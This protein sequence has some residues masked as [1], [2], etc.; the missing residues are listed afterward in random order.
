MSFGVWNLCT[1]FLVLF[2][3][4]SIQKA[5]IDI[6]YDIQFSD[7]E[8]N[9]LS[10]IIAALTPVKLTVDALCRK[11]A[12]L[13]TADA[14]LTFMLDTLSKQKSAIAL[15]LLEALKSRILLRRTEL[16]QIFQYLQKGS[17]D[18]GEVFKRISKLTNI[19]KIVSLTKRLPHEN[20]EDTEDMEVVQETSLP[21]SSQIIN[22]T[23][24]ESDKVNALKKKLQASID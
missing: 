9:V 1:C 8:F 6:S 5:L 19:K 24:L 15:E 11:D 21:I 23:V 10:S 14:S 22:E 7:E 18:V 3:K 20:R 12:N 2:I 13:L 16:S 17:Q 4:I